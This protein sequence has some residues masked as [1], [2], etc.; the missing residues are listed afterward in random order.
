MNFDFA[1]DIILEDERVHI[2]PMQETD[3]AFLL[4][5]LLEPSLNRYSSFAINLVGFG[6]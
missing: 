6:L 1:K 3:K 2:R 4:D 5:F